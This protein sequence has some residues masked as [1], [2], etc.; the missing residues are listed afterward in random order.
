MPRYC[1]FGDTVNTA[2][3]MESHGLPLNIH[4]SRQTRDL[5]ETNGNYIL[6]SRGEINI[7]GKGMTETYWLLGHKDERNQCRHG[8]D[9][10]VSHRDWFKAFNQDMKIKGSPKASSKANSDRWS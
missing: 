6:E 3:R 8:N 1:L 9:S 2:S 7:K 10:N 4:T 5:L